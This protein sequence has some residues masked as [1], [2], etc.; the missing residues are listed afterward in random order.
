MSPA[1]DFNDE[2]IILNPPLNTVVLNGIS[3]SDELDHNTFNE[4]HMDLGSLTIDSMESIDLYDDEDEPPTL[5]KESIASF[6]TCSA[7]STPTGARDPPAAFR[8]SSI[9]A[10][11]DNELPQVE[12]KYQGITNNGGTNSSDS[13]GLIDTF[14]GCLRP[15]FSAVNK[16][17]ENIKSTKDTTNTLSKPVD[18]W[19]IPIDRIM[20]DLVLIGTGIEGTVYLGKLGGQNVA[21]KRVKSE[22]ETNIKHLKKLNH[23]NVIKFRGVSVA[24]PLFYIVMDYCAYGSLYDVLKRRREKNSCTKPTQVL[25][26][27]KQISNGV[28]YLHSNKIVHRD[29]KSPNILI[30]DN[31]V[32]KISDFGTSKQLGNKQGQIMSFNGTSAWM[33][34]EVIRQEPCSE[35][36]DVWS[37]GIVLWEILTCAVPYHNIDPS[38]VMWGVGKG[39]LTLPI[40][41]SAP[42]GFKLLMTMCWNQRPL[43]RPSFQQII[44]HLNISEPEI[45]LFEQ[46]QEYAELTHA[47]SIEINE[48]LARLPTI[49]ISATLKMTNDELM[50]KRKE[51]LQHIADIRSHYQ[52]KLQQVNTLYIELS[53]LMMQLQKR[54]QEIKKKERLLN[55]QH[56]SSSGNSNGKKRSI[57]SLSEARKKSL[58]LIKAASFTLNDPIIKLSQTSTKQGQS[59]KLNNGSSNNQPSISSYNNISIHS[60]NTLT[61]S[62]LLPTTNNNQDSSSIKTVQRR[63]KGPGHR[64]NNSKGSTASW[65]PPSLSAIAD[66]EKKRASINIISNMIEETFPKSQTA[67]SSVEMIPMTPIKSAIPSISAEIDSRSNVQNRQLN[68]K[69][70]K[71]DLSNSINSQISPTIHQRP[72]TIFTYASRKSSSSDPE[73]FN[74]NQHYN[75]SR[76]RRRRNLNLNTNKITS[77]SSITTRSIKS[78]SNDQQ[79]PIADELENTNRMNDNKN[80]NE[81]LNDLRKYPRNVS[82]QLSPPTT[83][84]RSPS[85][86]QRKTF[87][88]HFPYSSSEEGE[89]EEIPS[90]HYILDDE[91]HRAIHEDLN[92]E[93]NGIFSSESEIYHENNKHSSSLKNEGIFSDEGGH[94]S[95][96][97]PESRESLVNSEPEHEWPNNE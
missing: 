72:P 88:R 94:L 91:K 34:P 11:T 28:N 48:Q 85:Y 55:I 21:C 27:S 83:N 16:L 1:P 90:D 39:S 13:T 80:D 33:A 42:G 29:L 6:T 49:D 24:S 95:D 59:I 65:T 37:F 53:S 40:P 70:L 30:A 76:Q 45:A 86:P 62:S 96:D 61:S 8:R 41:S 23:I 50:K 36:V 84:D 35:K 32:L 79:T 81:K 52:T 64:R 31:Y 26:W 9:T 82:F 66:Q 75:L 67:N 44:K 92:R 54:E 18:D 17:G 15:I 69:T 58:Q 73:D 57:N 38:A 14:L 71:L 60:N 97:R 4:Q 43:N 93:S 2:T 87:N 47:W 77:P 22:E 7:P 74:E 12:V 68:P 78:N 3:S 63:K 10:T 19:E 5:T 89:V 20:N 25:D 56:H 46:E 51:E